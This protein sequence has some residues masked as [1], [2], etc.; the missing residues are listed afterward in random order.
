MALTLVEAA[1]QNSGD[2]VKSVVIEQYAR[3]SDILRVLPFETIQGNSI[4]YNQEGALPGVGFRG[5]NEGYTESTGILNPET[6]SLV[7]A[8]GD[9]DVDNFI[10]KTMGQGIR[11]TQEMMKVK[12]LALRW[13][14]EFIKGDSTSNKKVFDGLQVRIIGNQLISNGT[15]SGGDPLSL[16]KLDE[17]I[18]AVQ[19]INYLLMNKGMR[20]RITQAARNPAIGGTVTYTQDSF[21]RTQTKYNDLEILIADEDNEGNQILPF[22]EAAASGGAASTSIY[23]LAIEE[24]VLNGIQDSE[25]EVKDLGEI[26]DKPV[27][28]TRIDWG[29]GIIIY[30]GRAAGRLYGISD[31]AATV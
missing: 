13:T 10:I 24:G 6:E 17:M 7:I 20:R 16:I 11:S 1:K 31:A 19:G 25:P 28:R 22:T 21:G 2:V 4:K 23:G 5:V 30:N 9:L 29:N 14:K 27:N 18:D 3:S 15:T 26:D 12:A 8:G